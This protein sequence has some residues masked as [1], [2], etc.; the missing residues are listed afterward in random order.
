MKRVSDVL[1]A[2]SLLILVCPLM[3]LVALAI[4]CETPGPSLERHPCLGR[5]GRRIQLLSFRTTEI[6]AEQPS[7]ARKP[8]RVGQ[9]LRI[10]RIESLPQLVNV[11]SGD[12]SFFDSD[13][14]APSFLE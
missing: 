11:L 2:C 3:G 14:R 10:T 12:M 8:T 5:N 7:W 1:V 9:F 6:N 4:K 13:A